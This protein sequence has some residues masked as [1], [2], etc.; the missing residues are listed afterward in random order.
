MGEIDGTLVAD[1]KVIE[2]EFVDGDVDMT[3]VDANDVEPIVPDINSI[4]EETKI[5]EL[6]ATVG[7]IGSESDN[8]A[9]GKS[10][11]AGGYFAILVFIT[12][13]LYIFNKCRTMQAPQ[14]RNKFDSLTQ[15]L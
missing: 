7:V 3:I 14:R 4:L 2:G 6:Y 11:G 1:A 13:I 10:L 15:L 9:S 12:I 5:E 8:P